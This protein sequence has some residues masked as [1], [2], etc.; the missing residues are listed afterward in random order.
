MPRFDEMPEHRARLPHSTHDLSHSFGF[1]ATCAHLLPVFHMMI[2]AGDSVNLG[3]S[4][5]LRTQPLQSAAMED[6]D[7]HTEYFFVPMQLLL[8]TFGETYYD[9]NDSFSSFVNSD[10]RTTMGFNF[11]VLDFATVSNLLYSDKDLPAVHYD[12]PS[13]L[14]GESLGQQAVRLCDHL[15]FSSSLVLGEANAGYIPNVFPYQ[16]LAYHCIYQYYYRLDTRERFDQ[17]VFNWDKY[18]ST[19]VVTLSDADIRKMFTLYYRPLSDDYFTNVKVSPIVDTLN[20]NVKNV[21]ETTNNWLTRSGVPGGVSNV[22]VSGNIIGADSNTAAATYPK[23]NLSNDPSD[24]IQTKF[25]INRGTSGTGYSTVVSNDLN[26]ANIRAMFANEKLWS[27]TGRAR[28]HYDDQ[29]LA[30]FG[31]QVPHDPKHEITCFGKDK[32]QIHIGEVISTAATSDA[33][34]GEIAGKGYGSQGSRMHYFKAPCHGVIM[35]IFS[36]TPRVRYQTSFAKYNAIAS[37]N[38]MPIPEYDH[39]GMQPVFGYET[40]NINDFPVSSIIGWQYRYEQF[41]RRYN[42]VSLAFRYRNSASYDGALSSWMLSYTPYI[43]SNDVTGPTEE[44]IYGPN[45]NSYY[46]FVYTPNMLNQL[47]L[48]QYSME[49][50]TAYETNLARIYAGDPFVIDSRVTCKLSSWMSDYSLPRLDV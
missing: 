13:G 30:H 41:K 10:S 21:L 4:F 34:L 24:S 36:I 7:C 29:T 43:M 2:D 27:I 40:G 9:I 42:R 39:L 31:Y 50:S 17:S 46:Y 12:A 5:N 22:I 48:A 38:D 45:M 47:F 8:Q 1:T 44:E 26:T 20:L 23:G 6:I 28:K 25:G 19:P 16:L 18:Y 32:S 14:V 49:W 33:P 11:P 37:R 3:F 35:T 15:Q